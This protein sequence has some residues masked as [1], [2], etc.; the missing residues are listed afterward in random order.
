MAPRILYLPSGTHTLPN[1][2]VITLNW[3][4]EPH[5]TEHQIWGG[6]NANVLGY[7][8][9]PVTNDTLDAAMEAMPEPWR[10][11]WCGGDPRPS[12]PAGRG[13]PRW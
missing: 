8:L 6:E 13:S 5:V 9:R 11:R 12:N 3:E 1:G 2:V 7:I 4:S 10:Y